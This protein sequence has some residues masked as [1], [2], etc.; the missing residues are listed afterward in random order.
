RGF[1]SRLPLQFP[2]FGAF[3]SLSGAEYSFPHM[4]RGQAPASPAALAG[5][6]GKRLAQLACVERQRLGFP[7]LTLL[8]WLTI[9]DEQRA[10]RAQQ[11][12]HRRE[13]AR[14]ARPLGLRVVQDHTGGM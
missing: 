10:D 1:E 3:V 12:E 8:G 5:M 11:H 6:A 4:T 9:G 13:Q 2:F 7:A 14:R